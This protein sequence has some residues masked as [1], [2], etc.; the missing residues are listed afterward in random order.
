VVS[1]VGLIVGPSI[2]EWQRGVAI[3]AFPLLYIG[4]MIG[5]NVWLF[6][7]ILAS[8]IKMVL[9]GFGILAA[10]WMLGIIGFLLPAMDVAASPRA[11]FQETKALLPHPDEPILAFQ[12][13]EWRGDEDLYYWQYRHPGAGVIGWQKDFDQASRDLLQLVDQKGRWRF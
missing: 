11:M 13:W 9:N 6:W 12:H 2:L 8:R 7:Q 3:E 10:G 4:V 5:L 1:V